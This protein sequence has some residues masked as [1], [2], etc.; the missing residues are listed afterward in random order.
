MGRHSSLARG[1]EHDPSRLADREGG[2]GVGAEV[3][4]LDRERL[5]PVAVEQLAHSSMDFGQATLRGYSGPGIDHSG[6]QRVQS[7]RTTP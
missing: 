6:R 4:P 7:A 5:G 2:A 3:E 1:Q